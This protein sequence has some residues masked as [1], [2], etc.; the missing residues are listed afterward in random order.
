MSAHIPYS[1]LRA[2][3]RVCE[4]VCVRVCLCGS[5]RMCACVLVCVRDA[6][7]GRKRIMLGV[8]PTCLLG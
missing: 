2:C 1:S 8:S 6:H 4:N 3:V 5:V 7:G